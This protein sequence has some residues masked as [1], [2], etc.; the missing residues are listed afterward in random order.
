MKSVR[1]AKV[2]ENLLPGRALSSSSLK[3]EVK[4]SAPEGPTGADDWLPPKVLLKP[5][6]QLQL[7]EKELGEELTRILN[8]NNPHAPHNIA[9]YNHKDRIFKASPNVDHLLVHFEFDGY[10]VFKVEDP[11]LPLTILEPA[12]STTEIGVVNSLSDE[13]RAVVPLP[14]APPPEEEKKPKGLPRNQFNF[15]ERAAQTIN[16]PFRD[17]FTNTEPPPAR[18]F[19]DTVN[20]WSIFDSYMED[21]Q[22][23]EKAAKEKTKAAP[24]SGSKGHKD[25]E[26][27]SLLPND[28]SAHN[29]EVY[30]KS[31]ELRK[32]MT[33]IERMANQNT[34][35]D[36]ADDYK[37]WEDA[38]D[39]FRDGKTG[40]LLPLWKFICEKEKKKQVTALCWNPKKVD[41][42]SVGFGSYDFSVQGPG[43]IACF[44]LKNPSHPE[45]LFVTETGVMCLDFHP[46]RPFM[47]AAGLYDGNVVV[48]NIAKKSETPIYKSHK[49]GKHTDPVWQ[50]YW[51]K[52]DL[53][54]N[55]NFFSV[56]SDGRITQWTLLKNE[57]IHT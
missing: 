42:F 46:Q 23:K 13:E 18:T 24:A 21:L 39:E 20:Q 50:I 26:K 3:L 8:A 2:Q 47:I 31:V 57:L 4:E 49:T 36:I 14:V 56:S 29:E 44:T 41:M 9:R 19:A 48:Y 7:T 17:R 32:A 53:D 6:G 37:Y 34:F 43:M 40:T 55:P 54:D 38:S 12:S 16:N 28:T 45:Y 25:D 33:I 51:Q 30:Y 35:D 5:P 1:K 10:L 11:P 52:D 27:I 22:M 15:S